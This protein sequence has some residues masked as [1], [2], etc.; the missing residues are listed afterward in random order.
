MYSTKDFL[1]ELALTGNQF[2][3][4]ETILDDLETKISCYR[5]EN[6]LLRRLL[7][8]HTLEEAVCP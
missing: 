1:E 3:L 8:Q 6:R 7:A 2:W 4:L 5:L